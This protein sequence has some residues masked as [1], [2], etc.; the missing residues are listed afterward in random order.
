MSAVIEIWVGAA[1]QGKTPGLLGEYRSALRQ[2]R[3]SNSCGTTLWLAPTR[4][5]RADILDRLLDD[6][7]PVC[8]A[9]NVFTFDAFA[10]TILKW[11]PEDVTA[12]SDIARNGLLRTIVLELH[13]AEKLPYFSPIVETS[14]FL[15]LVSAFISELKR[16]EIWPEQFSAACRRHGETPKDRELLLIY[17]RY[18]QKLLEMGLYIYA[19]RD[20]GETG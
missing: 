8:F 7:L 4:R 10:D 19:I 1:R 12:I 6:R 16:D 15:R 18:Q 13:Q 20:S 5:A 2:A 3:D 9:P 17:D 14:G 11:C